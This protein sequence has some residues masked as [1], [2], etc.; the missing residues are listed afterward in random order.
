VSQS[1]AT[2]LRGTFISAPVISVALG[3]EKKMF[4][5]SAE[6]Q[7]QWAV[8]RWIM[9]DSRELLRKPGGFTILAS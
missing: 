8:K 9:M 1:L 6:N 4:V 2:P 5:T 3:T 7:L